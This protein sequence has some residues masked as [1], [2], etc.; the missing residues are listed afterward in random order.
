MR[1]EII[2]GGFFGFK[3]DLSMDG[4]F[5]FIGGYIFVGFLGDNLIDLHF[6]KGFSIDTFGQRQHQPLSFWSDNLGL[7]Q[8][9]HSRNVLSSLVS[10]K[11]DGEFEALFID[12]IL[13]GDCLVEGI[14]IILAHRLFSC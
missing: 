12:H 1:R 8:L 4:A 14:A 6:A 11:I 7:V 3:V 10:D 5:S 9:H 13:K 2:D